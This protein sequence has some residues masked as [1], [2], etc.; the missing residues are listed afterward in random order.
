MKEIKTKTSEIIQ[1][2]QRHGLI[3]TETID[4]FFNYAIEPL[5][6]CL[7]INPHSQFKEY[8]KEVFEKEC[9]EKREIHNQIIYQFDQ[10]KLKEKKEIKQ[11]IDNSV[12]NNH[13]YRQ[14]LCSMF[15]PLLINYLISQQK[16]IENSIEIK[17]ILDCCAAPGSKTSQLVENENITIVGNDINFKRLQ[18]LIHRLKSWANI[19]VLNSSIQQIKGQYDCIL[20][21]VPCSGDGTLRK[22]IDPWI[23][24]KRQKS[25][26][27]HQLQL[28]IVKQ[29]LKHVNKNGYLIYSTCSLN[30]IEDE[31][32]IF[33]LL[34]LY[35]EKIEI[36][37]IHLLFPNCHCGVTNWFNLSTEIQSQSKPLPNT[38]L[39]PSIDN[40]LKNELTKCLRI[41]PQDYNSGGFFITALKIKEC[42]SES[43]EIIQPIQSDESI[44]S[45]QFSERN[46]VLWKKYSEAFELQSI[47]RYIRSTDNSFS[48][49]TGTIE[50]ESSIVLKGCK[51]LKRKKKVDMTTITSSDD[52]SLSTFILSEE[53]LYHINKYIHQRKIYLHLDQLK[54]LQ[55]STL[56]I[57]ELDT[58]WNDI[59]KIGLL[60]EGSIV[61][62]II[63]SNEQKLIFL[64]WKGNQSIYHNI[65]KENWDLINSL[66]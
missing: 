62:E 19:V 26:E 48:Y 9:E 6:I 17:T 16:S 7:R 49:Y 13:C 28:S 59:Q 5:P 18:T 41:F 60:E 50:D 55:T 45:I 35:G 14:E 1:E 63:E 64:G 39:P 30:P 43:K 20:C 52:I 10:L 24:W 4:E 51:I 46:E 53:G 37:D 11:I 12:E 42:I 66:L 56:H 38:I 61:M 36:I 25:I 3:T 58:K 34:Q 29:C 21:D 8:L 65:S 40:P 47:K 23:K 57:S 2:Y 33:S 22:S 27:T 31:A 44:Q 32:I 15:P 54:A